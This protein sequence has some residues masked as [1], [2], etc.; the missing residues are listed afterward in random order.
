[1]AVWLQREGLH[2]ISPSLYLELLYGF[3]NKRA[4]SFEQ[5]Q[6]AHSSFPVNNA[7]KKKAFMFSDYTWADL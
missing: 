5:T 1:M 4:L 6:K 7:E 3:Y 2:H